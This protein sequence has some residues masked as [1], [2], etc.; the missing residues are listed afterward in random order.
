M[1]NFL[2]DEARRVHIEN[3]MANGVR[4]IRFDE[5]SRL[6][7]ALSSAADALMRARPTERVASALG[8]LSD[9]G[10]LIA[11]VAL[12]GER[13]PPAELAQQLEAQ[14]HQVPY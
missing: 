2:E 4:I 10:C 7:G 1:G 12:T 11:S 9:A 6:Q 8:E 14:T 5:L 3:S 13:V